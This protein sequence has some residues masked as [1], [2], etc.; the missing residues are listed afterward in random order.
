M[1]PSLYWRLLACCIAFSVTLS[2]QRNYIDGTVVLRNGD[3][4]KGKIDYREWSINPRSIS[5][6]NGASGISVYTPE[7]ITGFS[8]GRDE[9]QTS[10]VKVYPYSTHHETLAGSDYDPTPYTKTVFLRMIARGRMN[11]YGFRDSTGTDYFFIRQG[12]DSLLQLRLISWYNAEDGQERFSLREVYKDQLAAA[13]N[14][15]ADC[16]KKINHTAYKE[17]DL[18]ALVFSYDHR[19]R[20]TVQPRIMQKVG[21]IRVYPMLGYFNSKLKLNNYPWDVQFPAYGSIIGGAG[22]EF[23]L[24]R[25]RQQFAIVVEALYHHFKTQS[26]RFS[27]F[28]VNDTEAKVEYNVLKGDILFRY[29]YPGGRVR[30]FI[31]AG[32]ANNLAVGNKSVQTSYD[33]TNHIS[34]SQ[35]FLDGAF[36][37][38]QEGWLAGLGVKAGRLLLECRFERGSGI[39]DISTVGSPITTFYF[40]AGFSL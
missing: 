10:T 29:T 7:R 21:S 4:L 6:Q 22:L 11:L 32:M 28:L 15:C 40:L 2:A 30:P 24:S 20:D 1:I 25:N 31:E 18:E 26:G 27:E 8:V 34:S 3:T 12:A 23:T 9:Y 39:S 35:P 13:M 16:L 17:T 14:D 19:G 5:F 37:T 33:Y 38:Y 36:H